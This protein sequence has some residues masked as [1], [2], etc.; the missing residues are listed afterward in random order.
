MSKCFLHGAFGY[1]SFCELVLFVGE[2]GNIGTSA[3][4]PHGI[5]FV[6]RFDGRMSRKCL[7]CSGLGGKSYIDYKLPF[8]KLT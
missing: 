3:H 2:H 7:V 4:S 5:P 1:V 8:G 6:A